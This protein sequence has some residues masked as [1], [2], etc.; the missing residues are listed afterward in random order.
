MKRYYIL[1]GRAGYSHNLIP[2]TLLVVYEV[3][4]ISWFFG[5]GLSQTVFE[6]TNKEQRQVYEDEVYE[7]EASTKYGSFV[8]DKLPIFVPG[9][10]ILLMMTSICHQSGWFPATS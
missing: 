8:C 6:V 4:S 2:V 10:T 7:D 1:G 5:L 3:Y 9:T